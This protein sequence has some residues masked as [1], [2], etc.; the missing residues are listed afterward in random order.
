MLS[1][2]KKI[3]A[4]VRTKV[5]KR[6]VSVLKYV[7]I[8]YFFFTKLCFNPYFLVFIICL[9]RQQKKKKKGGG[10]VKEKPF[11]ITSYCNLIP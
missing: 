1:T 9:F 6:C 2:D 11:K 4:G 10:G 5:Y 7:T 3:I 8:C